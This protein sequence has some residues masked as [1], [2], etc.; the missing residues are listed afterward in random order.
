MMPLLGEGDI[1]R[2]G[3]VK[4]AMELEGGDGAGALAVAPRERGPVLRV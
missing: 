3:G 1:V 4:G 2:G